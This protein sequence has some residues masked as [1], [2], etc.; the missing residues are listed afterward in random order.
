MNILA[1]RAVLNA[2]NQL[3]RKAHP[4]LLDIF[5]RGVL[6]AESKRL[7]LGAFLSIAVSPVGWVIV[8]FKKA[9]HLAI[10]LA[11]WWF[12]REEIA[13]YGSLGYM[14]VVLAAV[15]I[16]Y[17]EIYYELLDLFINLLVIVTGGGFLRWM[18]AGYISGTGFR[19]HYLTSGPMQRVV[20]SMVAAIPNQYRSRYD[21]LMNLYLDSNKPGNEE[22]LNRF[23][24]EYS[25]HVELGRH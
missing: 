14:L 2:D 10:L 25:Q 5:C 6:A 17:K 3:F 24:E 20:G 19:Q 18:C 9:I 4:V 21:E 7:I 12:L 16:F 11:V 13:R 8:I 15:A 1:K 23:L 22:N